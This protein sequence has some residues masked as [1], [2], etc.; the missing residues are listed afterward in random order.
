MAK[1]PQALHA[2]RRVVG[3]ALDPQGLN[4]VAC[5]G[6][7][8]SLALAVAASW[9]HHRTSGP[10]AQTRVGAVVVD[11]HIHPRSVEISGQAVRQLKALGLD[12]VRIYPATVDTDSP[13]GPEAA[14][15]TGRYAAFRRAMRELGATR[16]LTAHTRDD[17]AE[18]VLLGLARGSGTR[19]LAGIPAVRGPY[20]RPLLQLTR[21]DTEAICRHAELSWWQDPANQ[22]PRYLRS[23]IR[24]QIMPY[25]E[26]HLSAGI[27]EAL[28][29]TAEIAADDADHL[30][31]EA[32]RL[33]PQLMEDPDPSGAL[34]LRL[35]PLRTASAAIRRRVLALGVVAA[36]GAHPSSERLA[37]VERLT[38][39]SRSAGPVQ[40]EGGVSV[41]R[42]TRGSAEYGKLVFVPPTST[43]PSPA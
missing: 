6:G 24:T 14:A 9:H 1:T 11:H 8:D 16:L 27:R 21:A 5:S 32:K 4:L 25:L 37:A 39:G 28:A 19:S 41:Y 43:V 12:P 23:R 7:A 22:D 18:Q 2:A 15:R 10:S 3:E 30:E 35:H 34:R 38:T 20:R 26:E 33:F 17:Q 31:T 29:R 40:C 42:G 36:G 13:D